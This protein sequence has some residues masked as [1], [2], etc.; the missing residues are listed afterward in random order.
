MWDVPIYRIRAYVRKLKKSRRSSGLLNPSPAATARTR[1]LDRAPVQ[2]LIRGGLGADH[3]LVRASVVL[4]DISP[5][6]LF[7]FTSSN[8]AVG[9]KV[10]LVIEQPRTFY[11]QG[12]IVVC[13]CLSLRQSILSSE[14]PFPYRVGILFEFRSAAEQRAVQQYCEQLARRWTAPA[15][16]SN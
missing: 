9:E 16:A 2:L 10:T 1:H 6:G 13:K 3:A 8:V 7:L 11:V 14:A 12:R 5:R 15:T 4:H